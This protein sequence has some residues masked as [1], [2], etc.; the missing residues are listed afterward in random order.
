MRPQRE[1]KIATK[2][3]PVTQ[4]EETQCNLHH[5][6]KNEIK[7]RIRQ[8]NL[9]SPAYVKTLKPA[10]T[11][12]GDLGSDGHQHLN[13]EEVHRLNVKHSVMKNEDMKDHIIQNMC[14]NFGIDINK[15]DNLPVNNEAI[16]NM[17]MKDCM[18]AVFFT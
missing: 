5:H 10:P 3:P 1:K 11:A 2:I 12:R 13:F 4:L 8:V 18:W 9:G 16:W 7:V 14:L 15:L 6:S 17:F